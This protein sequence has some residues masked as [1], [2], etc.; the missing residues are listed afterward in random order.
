MN[1]PNPTAP[2]AGDARPPSH[3]PAKFWD[4]ARG[5][6]RV[7]DLLKS[8]LTLERRLGLLGGAPPPT[9]RTAIGSPSGRPAWRPIQR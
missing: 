8:Y 9:P 6:I 5:E 7:D 2:A 3:V 1:Q 4:P